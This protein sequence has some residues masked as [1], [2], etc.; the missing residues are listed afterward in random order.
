MMEGVNV[1]WSPGVH[2][3]LA[4]SLHFLGQKIGD[5]KTCQDNAEIQH[6]AF[7]YP[8]EMNRIGAWE[9]V[10][11]ILHRIHPLSRRRTT[12]PEEGARD[13]VS[14]CGTGMFA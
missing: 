4:G 5:P 12:N 14:E 9:R 2:I 10:R 13:E 1:W 8:S 11:A 7:E 6:L 3:C